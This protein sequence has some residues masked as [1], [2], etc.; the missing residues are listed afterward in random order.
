MQFDIDGMA[1]ITD[2]D[3]RLEHGARYQDKRQVAKD[4]WQTIMGALRNVGI[5][6]VPA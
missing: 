2:V 1:P 4:M 5:G 6:R 3:Q